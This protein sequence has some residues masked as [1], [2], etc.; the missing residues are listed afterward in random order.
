MGC[1]L[2]GGDIIK[3]EKKVKGG[4]VVCIYKNRL[5]FKVKRSKSKYGMKF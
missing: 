5:H 4:F 3:I 2:D 1:P